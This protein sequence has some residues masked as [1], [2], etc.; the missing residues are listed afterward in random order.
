MEALLRPYTPERPNSGCNEKIKMRT[1]KKQTRAFI[2]KTSE[3]FAIRDIHG[4]LLHP[5]PHSLSFSYPQSASIFNHQYH[6]SI[7]QQ[8]PLLPLPIPIAH[9]SLLSRSRT[10]SCPPTTRKNRAKDH[11]L[12]PKKP[13]PTKREEVKRDLKSATESIS[14]FLIVASNNRFGPDPN[15]LPKDFSVVSSTAS[16]GKGFEKVSGENLD[17]F[18][19]SVFTLSPPPSSLPLPKFSLRPKLGCNAEAGGIDAGA[20][21]N[22]R[23]LLRLR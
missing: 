23:R 12:T 13:K 5:P 1:P 11:S 19:G 2:S 9:Q 14:K 6:H 3:N 20:T 7:Q 15:D 17:T 16:I 10:L 22:L 8:P 18:S 21:D 4:G